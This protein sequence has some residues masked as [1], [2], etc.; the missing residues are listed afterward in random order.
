M[1]VYYV[2]KQ[3]LRENKL[4]GEEVDRMTDITKGLG[5]TLQ[6]LNRSLHGGISLEKFVRILDI[7]GYE[8]MIGKRKDGRAVEIRS[9]SQI[10]RKWK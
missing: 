1:D 3:L 9:L 8:L 2:E 6:S 4:R 10:E 7:A 5:I